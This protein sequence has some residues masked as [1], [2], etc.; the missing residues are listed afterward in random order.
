MCNCNLYQLRYSKIRLLY[1][2]KIFTGHGIKFIYIQHLQNV[3]EIGDYYFSIMR[4]LLV[5]L[6]DKW[7]GG[8]MEIIRNFSRKEAKVKF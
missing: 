8:D 1:L 7:K 5:S 3:S 2:M 4:T 6:F